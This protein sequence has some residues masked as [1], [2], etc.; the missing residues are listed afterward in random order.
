[1]PFFA[2]GVHGLRV[3]RRFDALDAFGANDRG[4]FGAGFDIETVSRRD[5][6]VVADGDAEGDGAAQAVEDLV[7]GVAVWGVDVA[8]GV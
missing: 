5:G 2:R 8:R 7:V 6:Y 1:L 3:A 4:V